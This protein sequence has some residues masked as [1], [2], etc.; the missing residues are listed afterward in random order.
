MKYLERK[1]SQALSTFI[2]W[3]EGLRSDTGFQDCNHVL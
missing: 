3:W 2:K 1:N